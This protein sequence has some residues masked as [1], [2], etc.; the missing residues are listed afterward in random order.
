[1]GLEER[2]EVKIVLRTALIRNGYVR[3]KSTENRGDDCYSEIWNKQPGIDFF[4]ITFDWEVSSALVS[5]PLENP[6]S[7]NSRRKEILSI[8]ESL[9]Y[10]SLSMCVYQDR[11]TLNNVSVTFSECYVHIRCQLPTVGW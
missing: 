10:R 8:V 3:T 1:M 7:D 4:P 11:S 5:I 6:W 9:G 2:R